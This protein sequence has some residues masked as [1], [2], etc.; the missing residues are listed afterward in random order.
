MIAYTIYSV[1]A[2]VRREA[3]TL[4]SESGYSVTAITL[5]EK[6]SPMSYCIDHVDICEL[7]IAKYRG[8]NIISYLLSYT[9]FFFMAF[10]KCTQIFIHRGIDVVHVHNMP[11]LLVFSAII[12][13]LMGK[14]VILDVHD[15]VFE[16][17]SSKFESIP[18]E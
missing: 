16:T 18:N 6:T 8:N 9:H 17:Y 3:E 12:P 5:K 2:R 4:A 11:N 1:D 13:A 7:N 14:P 10:L 15:T